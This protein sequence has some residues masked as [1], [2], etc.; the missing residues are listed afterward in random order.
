MGRAMLI[1]CAGVLISLGIM[2]MA[3][4]KHGLELTKKTITYADYT[5]AKNAAHTAI[6]MA[7]QEINRDQENK[8]EDNYWPKVYTESNPWHKVI[9]GRNVY[10]YTEY[11]ENPDE[12]FFEEE[13]LRM[14]A[15]AEHENLSV[16]V[17]S[18]YTMQPFSA[19][20]PDFEGALG[21]AAPATSYT[22][23]SNGN[24][25]INGTSASPCR[26]GENTSVPPLKTS[27]IGHHT[28]LDDFKSDTDNKLEE[29]EDFIY[30]PTDELIQRLRNS[31]GVTYIRDNFNE[32]MGSPTSPGV[33]FVEDSDARITG[34]VREGWGILVI[35]TS[36]EVMIE[37]NGSTLHMGGNFTFNGLVIFENAD[38]FSGAGTPTVNGSVLVGN[39]AYDSEGSPIQT[40]IDIR[41]NIEINY[42]C[43]GADYAKMAAANAVKQNKYTRIVTTE[44]VIY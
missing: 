27:D 34:T 38:A 37:E 3:A 18:Q 22:F 12:L 39:P 40:D 5:M 35:R 11:I 7:M 15:I 21:I 2:G 14:H 43:K 9:N 28:N 24:A 44:N 33:F 19:L 26:E 8:G 20:V 36:G 31:D 32:S 6:Q 13:P 42:D 10:V 1:I 41:G 29:D 23:S 4:S 25:H 17:I 16:K 30:E